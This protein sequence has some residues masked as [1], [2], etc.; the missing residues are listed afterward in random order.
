[1]SLGSCLCSRFPRKPLRPVTRALQKPTHWA[2]VIRPSPNW[3]VIGLHFHLFENTAERGAARPCWDVIPRRNDRFNPRTSLRVAECQETDGM[4][5][6]SALP[7]QTRQY[8]VE[9]IL[10]DGP[11]DRPL[12]DHFRFN[13]VPRSTCA[14]C[15]VSLSTGKSLKTTEAAAP[16]DGVFDP[17]LCRR[18][19]ALER[20]A[21]HLADSPAGCWTESRENV[22]KDLF[23]RMTISSASPLRMPS[24]DSCERSGCQVDA[25][26]SHSGK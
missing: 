9:L 11:T 26:L 13:D 15:G 5:I 2:A 18:I 1:M 19:K 14:S 10:R 24:E 21:C 6:P 25:K 20:N 3:V 16:P 8:P 23:N 12:P 4:W 22:S 17:M 7:V